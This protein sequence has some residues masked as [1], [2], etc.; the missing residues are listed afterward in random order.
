MKIKGICAMRILFAL[1]FLLAGCATAKK[2]PAD[3][4]ASKAPEKIAPVKKV[5]PKAEPVIITPKKSEDKLFDDA[6][7]FLNIQELDVNGD[8]ILELIAVYINNSGVSC[9]KVIKV[10]PRGTLFRANFP[11]SQVKLDVKGGSP[12]ITVKEKNAVSGKTVTRSYHWDGKAFV[13]K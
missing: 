1:I 5:I 8:N 13:D 4:I 7:T 3:I 2:K 9:V 6:K 10:N 12:V 11:A